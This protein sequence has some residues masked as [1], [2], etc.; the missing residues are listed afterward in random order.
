MM[1]HL[2]TAGK[3]SLKS[4]NMNE[5]LPVPQ[6]TTHAIQVGLIQTFSAKWSIKKT[7]KCLSVK[8]SDTQSFVILVSEYCPSNALTETDS[9]C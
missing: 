4:Q 9:R 3:D 2:S 8:K 1:I 7:L 6:Y 5:W